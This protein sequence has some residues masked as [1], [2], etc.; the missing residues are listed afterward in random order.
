MYR[1]IFKKF[2]SIKKVYFYGLFNSI[3]TDADDGLVSGLYSWSRERK[4]LS[5][6]SYFLDIKLNQ[7]SGIRGESL[8]ASF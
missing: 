4:K 7:P 2:T 8:S 5:S 3:E 6:I 1:N